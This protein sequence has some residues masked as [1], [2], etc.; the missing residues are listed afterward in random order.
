MTRAW[1]D[2]AVPSSG[3]DLV[4]EGCTALSWAVR[5]GRTRAPRNR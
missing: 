5:A 3:L 1:G 4:A 2:F